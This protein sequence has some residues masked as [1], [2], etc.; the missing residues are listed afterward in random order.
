MTEKDI[1]LL[2]EAPDPVYVDI[3]AGLIRTLVSA[4][5]GFGAGW[6]AGV[7]GEQIAMLSA[8]LAILGTGAWSTYQKI[9]SNRKNKRSS[10]A[11]ARLSAEASAQAG[12]PVP[13]IV[14]N[15]PKVLPTPPDSRLAS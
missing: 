1:R 6:A 3:I 15:P 7:T 13:F 8:V 14:L 10:E 5:A 2:V 4:A 9:Q 11:S 12:E